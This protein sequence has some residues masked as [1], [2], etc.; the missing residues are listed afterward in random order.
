[1]KRILIVDDNQDY[2]KYLS[3]S[4][5]KANFH[6]TVNTDSRQAL[7]D[8]IHGHYDLILLDIQMPGLDGLTFLKEYSSR[9][10]GNS[11]IWVVTSYKD[12]RY[13]KKVS[14]LGAKNFFPKD[15]PRKTIT[16]LVQIYFDPRILNL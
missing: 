15:T 5:Q 9:S 2:A 10:L 12:Y 11:P 6:V 13:T 4:L 14:S 16:K 3:I 1:M 7:R 8:A